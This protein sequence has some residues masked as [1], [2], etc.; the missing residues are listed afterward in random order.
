MHVQTPNYLVS[1][2]YIH[3]GTRTDMC[4]DVTSPLVSE[5]EHSD[6]RDSDLS[7]DIITIGSPTTGIESASPVTPV[8]A[9]PDFAL[10]NPFPAAPDATAIA[11]VAPN[12]NPTNAVAT[13]ASNVSAAI[14]PNTKPITVTAPIPTGTA[15]AA[16]VTL[17]PVTISQ[18]HTFD[19]QVAGER[20][21]MVMR[22][23]T[24]GVIQGW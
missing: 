22:G 10:P 4:K 18:G 19:L 13:V 9:T 6:G 14:G 5:L 21:Y 20:W 2:L 16:P 1:H 12:I 7:I 23:T 24:I 3:Y 17:N 11:V 8:L 15:P